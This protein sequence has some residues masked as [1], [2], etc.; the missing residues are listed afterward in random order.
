MAR[1]AVEGGSNAPQS[2]L[3]PAERREQIIEA[4]SRVIAQ[5]GFWGFAVRQVADECGLTEPAVIYHFKN[6]VGL[7]IAVLEHR[8]RE[9][10]TI[11]AHT[12]GVEAEDVWNGMVDFGI[13][14]LCAAL[15]ARNAAQPEMVRLYT[16]LQGESL[17]DHHPAY[18][19]FQQREERV[20]D[21]MT[22][23]A[24]RDGIENPRRE[25]LAAL[26]MMDGIQVRWLREPDAVDL[27]AEW[28]AYADSRWPRRD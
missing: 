3:A 16:V 1:R 26:S 23:A 8:D 6:K 4:A 9:D 28:N 17:N 25:A 7:L 27:V 12:L 13:R 5:N 18:Q 21:N 19:Y 24:E 11:F 22:R 10:M 2:R 14:E 20:L 15:V